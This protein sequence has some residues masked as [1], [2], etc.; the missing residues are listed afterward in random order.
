MNGDYATLLC[1]VGST[2][3]HT[4][5]FAT[6]SAQSSFRIS[7][8]GMGSIRSCVLGILDTSVIVDD[9]HV[10]RVAVP[11]GEAGPPLIT[12]PE[13]ELTAAIALQRLDDRHAGS[14]T[15]ASSNPRCRR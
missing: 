10:V 12:H 15:M 7:P 8:G 3:F 6:R 9:L 13:A 11:P 5:R 4:V 2:F 1:T 14:D